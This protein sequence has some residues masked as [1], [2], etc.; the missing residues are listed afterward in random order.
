MVLSYLYFNRCV[1]TQR[2]L[3]LY[4]NK[5]RDNVCTAQIN[6]SPFRIHSPGNIHHDTTELSVIMNLLHI[7]GTQ[8]IPD[9]QIKPDQLMLFKICFI[10]ESLILFVYRIRIRVPEA[11][12]FRIRR[13]KMPDGRSSYENRFSPS[14]PKADVMLFKNESS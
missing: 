8:V 2:I 6:R 12:P 4:L 14:S 9:L 10:I 11:L 5:I 7:N 3:S 13:E 1:P